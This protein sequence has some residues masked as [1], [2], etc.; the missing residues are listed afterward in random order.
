MPNRISETRAVA[1]LKDIM[2]GRTPAY[3]PD[4][5]VNGGVTWP[6]PVPLRSEKDA[7]EIQIDRLLSSAIPA[8]PV[9]NK[10]RLYAL[11]AIFNANLGEMN[12]ST[13][14]DKIL[15][16][17]DRI[18]DK[19]PRF[20]ETISPHVVAKLYERLAKYAK[21]RGGDPREFPHL[22]IL[23]HRRDELQLNR[24]DENFRTGTISNPAAQTANLR[25]I[26][27]LLDQVVA[28]GAYFNS[29]RQMVL[30]EILEN[31]WVVS[32]WADQDLKIAEKRT[33]TGDTSFV[34]N[35][36]HYGKV[37]II[38]DLE[39][40]V[41]PW[42]EEIK[43]QLKLAPKSAISIGGL[44]KRHVEK[45]RVAISFPKQVPE[46][47]KNSIRRA[48]PSPVRTNKVAKEWAKHVLDAMEAVIRPNRGNF[49]SRA[50]F[51][52][53]ASDHREY[54]LE[55]ASVD[56]SFSPYDYPEFRFRWQVLRTK[57]SEMRTFLQSLEHY[58]D[59]WRG[60]LRDLPQHHQSKQLA[61]PAPTAKRSAKPSIAS[62]ELAEAANAP[63]QQKL[64]FAPR[65]AV[66]ERAS[67]DETRFQPGQVNSSTESL[68]DNSDMCGHRI[69]RSTDVDD[70][71]RSRKRL[72]GIEGRDRGR[73]TSR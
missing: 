16:V 3:I 51:L 4:G 44:I 50:R 34:P 36:Y 25:E 33:K 21:I 58:H 64:I 42:R 17:I 9:Y 1:Y 30:E 68:R 61:A 12:E 24:Y 29:L 26:N 23:G 27:T 56:A 6:R 18:Y 71:S 8:T 31:G 7:I 10:Q 46:G 5:S 72:R 22:E 60:R 70:S 62:S 28:D 20:P 54:W 73:S 2:R 38:K 67:E 43:G 49:A 15:P 45:G 65:N 32:R 48:P 47:I 39:D 53:T 55:P 59:A 57:E 63:G 41:K 40:K 35:S 52:K 69:K 13:D 19:R 14:V 11:N 66:K 37:R